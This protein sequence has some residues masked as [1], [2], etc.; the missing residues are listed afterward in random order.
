MAVLQTS[1]TCSNNHTFIANAKIRARCP[2]CGVMA[3]VDFNKPSEPTE[4]KEPISGPVLL[5]RGKAVMPA[6]ASKPKPKPKPA[7]TPRNRG[8]DTRGTRAGAVNTGPVRKVAAGIVT[9]RGTAP[10]GTMPKVKKMPPKTAVAR[11][12]TG[13]SRGGPVQATKNFMQDMVTRYGPR[14][15]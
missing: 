1:F 10:K 15:R 12:V 13:E 3:R 5:R 8:V 4:P 7:S 14:G 2:Y 11:H 6:R 9:N